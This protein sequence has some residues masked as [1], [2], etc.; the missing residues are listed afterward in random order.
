[1][2]LIVAFLVLTAPAHTAWPPPVDGP[3]TRGF[4]VGPNPF[5]GGQHRGVDLGAVPGAAVRAPCRGEVVVAG[6]VGTSGRVVTLLCGRWR[7][8]AMPL[9]VVTVRRGAKVGAGTRLGTVGRLPAHAGLHLGVRRD[10]ARFGYVDP[11]RFL[12]PSRPAPPDAIGR[13]GP[14]GG[15]PRPTAAPAP[16]PVAAPVAAA[17]LSTLAPWPAWAGLALVLGGVGVRWR[18]VR[19]ARRAASRTSTAAG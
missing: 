19:R 3:V 5:E 1:M 14:R 15:R 7:V 18:G 10:G 2:R 17:P 4:D 16:R 11:L 13:R 6:R 9:D 8:S 12:G